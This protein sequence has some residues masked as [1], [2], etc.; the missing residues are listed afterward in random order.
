MLKRNNKNFITKVNKFLNESDDDFE[1]VDEDGMSLDD[2]FEFFDDDEIGEG[3][4]IS[5]EQIQNDPNLSD[6][7][8]K[9]LIAF[10][11]KQSSNDEIVDLGSKRA[12]EESKGKIFDKSKYR[13]NINFEPWKEPKDPTKVH[14]SKGH[15]ANAQEELDFLE[16][17]FQKALA[18][19]NALYVARVNMII[20]LQNK[21]VR[22]LEAIPVVA[23][24]DDKRNFA[25]RNALGLSEEELNNIKQLLDD[26][27]VEFTDRVKGEENSQFDSKLF[28][29][30]NRAVSK[31]SAKSKPTFNPTPNMSDKEYLRALKKYNAKM[32]AYE[33]AEKD[34]KTTFEEEL[35]F[36]ELELKDK[37]INKQLN[38]AD[39]G[40][41][42]SILGSLMLGINDISML[43]DEAIDKILS[44]MEK[45]TSEELD[46]RLDSKNKIISDLAFVVLHKVNGEEEI[47]SETLK[48]IKAM[49]DSAVY[50]KSPEGKAE[51]AKQLEIS[52]KIES[53]PKK[54]YV[55]KMGGG[56]R[57]NIDK[58]TAL[59]Q[60]ALAVK[61]ET[62]EFDPMKIFNQIESELKKR[63]DAGETSS[64]KQLTAMTKGKIQATSGSRQEIVKILQYYNWYN[65]NPK[66]RAEINVAIAKKFLDMLEVLDLVEHEEVTPDAVEG[67]SVS[68]EFLDMAS[69]TLGKLRKD[70]V[71]NPEAL[72][73]YFNLFDQ[74]EYD[75]DDY[76][77]ENAK[78]REELSDLYSGFIGTGAYRYFASTLLS[79]F[80]KKH[81]GK[82][83]KSIR[84][85]LKEFFSDPKYSSLG[86]F[87]SFG[88]D[89]K[90][91]K[92]YPIKPTGKK[93]FGQIM[94]PIMYL[95]QNR[96]GVKEDLVLKRDRFIY[97]DSVTESVV[98][99]KIKTAVNNARKIDDSVCHN[100][101]FSSDNNLRDMARDI[102]N[103]MNDRNS[104]IGKARLAYVEMSDDVVEDF[105]LWLED[106]TMWNKATK[107][108]IAGES[109]EEI[110]KAIEKEKKKLEK[111]KTKAPGKSGKIGAALSKI[112]AGNLHRMAEYF[113]KAMVCSDI[114]R[115]R[116]NSVDETDPEVIEDTR[117][118]IDRFH[119]YIDM[120]QKALKSMVKDYPKLTEF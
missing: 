59:Y 51:F 10:F 104:I 107:M 32:N 50:R 83:E 26:L 110:E 112:G 91:D 40:S 5:I 21:L 34:G 84:L 25:I 4:E 118:I 48:D 1:F 41:S 103:M 78:R 7:E 99:N 98:F 60:E 74:E 19:Q 101:W 71:S 80:Y 93:E 64:F 105:K 77:P 14:T 100:P 79:E 47:A 113:L 115:A 92:D 8:K 62:G 94:N 69:E 65:I 52:K 12:K 49:R 72:T 97:D 33:N 82:V 27:I 44:E 68:D 46:I 117:K 55:K 31:I 13:S 63:A 28:S 119:E 76:D 85:G 106:P 2:D 39:D 58:V 15:I 89:G 66:G 114:E 73:D 17:Y 70:M 90:D 61:Q 38:S 3:G 96:S 36:A 67:F 43:T 18:S 37:D 42:D 11:E 45:M 24:K 16:P 88:K 6:E 22:S 81:G 75:P 111:T 54:Y 57:G 20:R 86:I 120:H 56:K 9:E 35:Y 116:K 109:K 53:I 102:W 29:L 30:W 87:Q 23:T 108:Q 95:V